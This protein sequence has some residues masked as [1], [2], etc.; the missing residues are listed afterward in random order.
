MF[1]LTEIGFT[2]T[3]LG[4]VLKVWN[5][6]ELRKARVKLFEIAA[7]HRTKSLTL[8]HEEAASMAKAIEQEIDQIADSYTE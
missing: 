3:A 5:R 1:N 4:R 2:A 6:I 7:E 8:Q